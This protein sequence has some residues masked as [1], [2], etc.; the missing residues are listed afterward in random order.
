MATIMRQLIWI[1]AMIGGLC[2]IS[3]GVAM[4]DDDGVSTTE[5]SMIFSV[6]YGPASLAGLE[7]DVDCDS[8]GS[9]GATLIADSQGM[10]DRVHPFRVRLDTRTNS[11]GASQAQTWIRE[12]GQVRRFRSQFHETPRVATKSVIHGRDEQ[13]LVALPDAGHDLLSWMLDIRRHIQDEGRLTERL[14]YPVWDGW[15]L[16]WLDVTPG[17]VQSMETEVGTFEVQEFELRRT[18][19]HHEGEKLFEAKASA[20]RLGTIWFEV[21]PRALPV[22]M[23]FDAPIGRVRIDI[24]AYE[25]AVCDK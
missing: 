10:A 12:K 23:A 21:T 4:A 19:L 11:R 18:Q 17:K 16:V 15:K 6:G 14:R 7:L 22:G 1:T 24:E 13:E 20:E 9:V 2:T 5:E 3:L 25:T 8:Q